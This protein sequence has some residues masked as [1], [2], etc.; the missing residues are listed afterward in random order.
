MI[1]M[2]AVTMCMSKDNHKFPNGKSIRAVPFDI[3]LP[4]PYLMVRDLEGSMLGVVPVRRQYCLYGSSF[5]L[6][7]YADPQSTNI[8]R[9]LA[10]QTGGELVKAY[11]DALFSLCA[12][13]DIA[14]SSS[15]IFDISKN[16]LVDWRFVLL[17]DWSRSSSVP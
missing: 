8:P 2:S 7:L 5:E 3:S 16:K 17:S 6:L 9:N 4:R 13:Y 14:G 1:G 12:I 11:A 15:F 10:F